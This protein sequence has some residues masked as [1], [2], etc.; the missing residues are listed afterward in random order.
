MSITI[1][2]ALSFTYVSLSLCAAQN[3]SQEKLQIE[4]SNGARHEIGG[5]D[6]LREADQLILY[7]PGYYRKKPPG[8]AGIDVSVVGGKIVE[9]RDRAKAVFIEKKSDPGPIQIGQEGFVLSGNGAA[10]KWIVGNLHVG[11]AINVGP[12]QGPPGAL[13]SIAGKEIPP[14]AELP[15][16]PGAYYRKAVSSLD[17]WTGIGG[18]VKL[19]EPRVDMERLDKE[20]NQPLDNFSVYMGGRAGT[21]EIDAGLTWAFTEDEQGHRSQTR[22]AWHPFWRN[23]KWYEAPKEKRYYWSPGDVVAMAVMV[24]APGKL[25]LVIADAQAN[26]QRMFMTEFDAKSFAPRVLRQFKRVNAIDQ[27]HNEGKPVQAT[28]AQ[29]VGAVWSETFLLRGAGANAVRL[30]MNPARFTD[31]RC[32]TPDKVRVSVTEQER[33]HGGE[34]IDIYGTPIKN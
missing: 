19:G 26:P 6:K 18:I 7:T 2:C 31:M 28:K 9:V 16:F 23:E 30:P 29:V 4:A 12:A 21:Q 22:N 14:A 25:R 3:A 8:N 27:R 13:A 5:A 20:D 1:L 17:V 11:D 15:C 10:R 34:A 33:A 24:A 32:P